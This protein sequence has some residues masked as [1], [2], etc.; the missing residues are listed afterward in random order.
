MKIFFVSLLAMCSLSGAFTLPD[1]Y[2][3]V[4]PTPGAHYV[5]A[6]SP[7]IVRFQQ[8]DPSRLR[9]KKSCIQVEDENG[10]VSGTS[11]LASDSRTLIFQP[12]KPFPAGA[13]INVALNPKTDANLDIIHSAR[14]IF[15][16]AHDE[17][18]TPI[19]SVL[20]KPSDTQSNRITTEGSAPRIMPNGVS[21]P[22]DFPHIEVTTQKETAE[23]YLF[24]NH[25]RE[26]NPYNIIF[27][28]DGSPVWYARQ[29]NGDRRW[30]F[31][32]QEN[33]LITMLQRA[34]GLKYKSYN[35]NFNPVDEY[36][37]SAGYLT[38][39][40]E[41][42]LLD[43]GHYLLFGLRTVNVDMSQF[44]EGAQTDVRVHESTIQ[45]YT[46]D[47]QLI[48]NWPALEHLQDG[49]PFAH[50][51]HQKVTAFA[52]P[53]MNAIDIDDDGHI[54]LS[55]RNLDEITKI[56]RQTGEIIWRLGGEH[57]QFTFVN[58]PLNGFNWQHDVRSLGDGYYSLFDNGREHNPSRSRAVVY[59]L[60]TENKTATLVWEFGNPP[61]T[62]ISFYM[63]NVQK[64]PNDNF[65]IN[66]AANYRPKATEVTPDG[67]VVYEM[68][69]VDDYA[70]YR[71]FRFPW[72]GKLDAPYLVVESGV[73]YLSLI[74]NKF[75]DADVD[76]YKIYAGT[77][78]HPTTLL[79]TCRTTLK[80]IYDLEDQQKYF[81]RVTAV[82]AD[83]R[84]S[85]FS[86][87]KSGFVIKKAPNE[88]MLNNSDFANSKQS[89][90]LKVV[91]PSKATWETTSQEAHIMIE[92]SDGNPESITLRQGKIFLARNTQYTLEFD[93][94]AAAPRSLEV[95]LCDIKRPDVD[96]AS[97]GSL[98]LSRSKQHHS[99]PF[100]I[101]GN[102][103]LDAELKFLLGADVHDV[104]L[105][106][107]QLFQKGI[108]AAENSDADNVPT[109]GF[110]LFENYPNPF[111]ATTTL[112]FSLPTARRVRLTLYNLLGEELLTILDEERDAGEHRVS[113][114][115]KDFASGLYFVNLSSDG[116][117]ETRKVLLQK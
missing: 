106:N 76:Y 96:L 69:F 21:V 37:A 52:F 7:I 22:S 105:D 60:D 80:Q 92:N 16:V 23:G 89:W 78:P 25:W 24:L 55:S 38:D 39:E 99:Y 104:F 43:N 112:R 67:E 91:E 71:T 111:N 63:G 75:G 68:N 109:I 41:F 114:D 73:N 84:E 13:T 79:D 54:L 77:D 2:A 101:S 62:D 17:S 35:E 115:A 83:G 100:T 36:A 47:H 90:L 87:D 93:V 64:L 29:Q 46:A 44:V 66:W 19:E 45:E 42:I 74:F 110:Q 59:K 26:Q 50:D 27:N 58:D 103:V 95:Q 6:H 12:D 51:F 14:Y 9:N 94:W 40:H 113:F 49:L 72:H 70:C 56:N 53:H 20:S 116:F 102:V 108:S 48:F 5:S 65:L 88:N 1:G 18:A 86:E 32:V 97:I 3:Y 33:G 57:N 34:G 11:I 98:S 15:H 28:N 82:S 85:V 117:S 61:R 81:F 30:N 107:V 4:S 31:K 10:I 8:L